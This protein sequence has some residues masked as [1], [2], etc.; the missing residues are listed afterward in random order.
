MK[1]GRFQ[2]FESCFTSCL[3]SIVCEVLTT[4]YRQPL[5]RESSG[6]SASPPPARWKILGSSRNNEVQTGEKYSSH[7]STIIME[8]QMRG[9]GLAYQVPRPEWSASTGV[10]LLDHWRFLPADNRLGADRGCSKD[11]WMRHGEVMERG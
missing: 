10:T 3:T 9:S 7:E 4:E 1:V 6:G 5:R 8:T 11:E 2:G